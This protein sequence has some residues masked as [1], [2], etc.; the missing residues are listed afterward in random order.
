MPLVVASSRWDSLDWNTFLAELEAYRDRFYAGEVNRQE[1]DYIRCLKS[2]EGR[3]SSER[4][5]RIDDLLDFINRWE[6]RTNRAIGRQVLGDWIRAHAETLDIIRN[7]RLET[8]AL[9]TLLPEIVGLYKDLLSVRAPAL[10]HNWSDACTSKV[11]GQLAPAMFVMWDNKI[12]AYA[13]SDYGQFMVSMHR[14]SN[15]LITESPADNGPALEDWL[16][17][18]LGYRLRKTL[19]KYLDEYNWHVAVGRGYRARGL[20]G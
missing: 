5:A 9:R 10:L 20:A 18:H 17:G 19:A 16:Q 14:L 4:A 13:A 8:D 2:M 3:S 15:R 1:R 7:Y 12:K 6:C 11:L